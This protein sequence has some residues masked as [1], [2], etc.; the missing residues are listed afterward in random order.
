MAADA[1]A[2]ILHQY[3][4]SPFSEK[5]RVLFGIKGLEWHAC[6][7]PI[8]M[9]KP[10]LTGLTGGYRKI[11]VLQIGA[12]IYCDTQIIA[13]E[14]ERRFPSPS[15]FVGPDRGLSYGIGAWIDRALFMHLVTV[16][17]AFSGFLAT[18]EFIADRKALIGSFDVDA[19]RAAGPNASEQLRAQFGWL[20]SQLDGKP[21]L[22]GEKPGLADASLYHNVWFLRLAFP[23][24]LDV[25]DRNPRLLEWE[26]R[27]KGI[28]HGTRRETN[29]EAALDIAQAATSAEPPKADPDEPNGLKPGDRVAVSADDYGRD[30]IAG[31][32]VSSSAQ[33]IAMRREDSRVGAVVVHFPRAGFV[34]RRA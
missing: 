32:L 6:D 21:F 30:A 8:V 3:D 13:R 11:P 31:E 34:V 22:L 18:E 2:I 26:R 12:D 28:G 1:N 20:D 9:P 23:N 33:H 16:V 5:V 14:L 24:G 7:Q 29:R 15:L 27:V 19:L 4:I 10:E 25:L 17:F